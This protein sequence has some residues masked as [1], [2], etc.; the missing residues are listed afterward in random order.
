[1]ENRFYHA[2]GLNIE[3]IAYDLE[4][5]FVSQGYQVQHFRSG[6]QTVVQLR[7]GGDFEALVG[8]QAALT[9]I[10]QSAPDGMIATIGQQQWMDKAAIGTIGMLVLWPLIFTAGAGFIRQAN[11]DAQVI[12]ALDM[13]VRRQRADVHIGPVP[14]QFQEG[15]RYGPPPP[16]GPQA[17]QQPTPNVPPGAA[18][19]PNPEPGKGTIQCLNCQETND[20]EDFYCS[21]C[22]KPLA[23]L[24]KRCP[25][26]KAEVKA[27]AAFCTRCGTAFS[28]SETPD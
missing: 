13:V 7:K 16:G 14:P 8:M 12:G 11:L 20:A 9:V 28:Q 4:G 10:L 19:Q 1:M 18:P 6:E 22:G 5:L 24:K 15:M 26:C 21:H 23:L 27:N 25:Q 2:P 17:P 3:R